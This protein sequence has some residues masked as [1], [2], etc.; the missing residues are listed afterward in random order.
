M[1][2]LYEAHRLVEQL[3]LDRDLVHLRDRLSPEVAEMVYYGFW[4]CAK[5]DALLAFIREAQQPVTRRGGAQ[6]STRATCSSRAARASH[7]LYDEAIA[8]MEGGG[9]YD[10]T[11]AE[12]FLRILGLP[13]RVQ[14]RVR[15]RG[16]ASAA[17]RSEPA[18][19]K[20]VLRSTPG[21]P[22]V[23]DL[24]AGSAAAAVRRLARPCR[25][26]RACV[27]GRRRRLADCWPC[28]AGDHLWRARGGQRARRPADRT[29]GRPAS[30]GF[31]FGPGESSGRGGRGHGGDGRLFGRGHGRAVSIGRPR[32]P[33]A[34][35]G[36]RGSAGGGA[37]RR[38]RLSSDWPPPPRLLTT[39][40]GGG[41]ARRAASAC[42]GLGGQPGLGGLLAWSLLVTL[43]L[44]A[45]VM[46]AR[47]RCRPS[48]G[49]AGRDSHGDGAGGHGGLFLSRAAV[50]R[51]YPLWPRLVCLS[52]GARRHRRR[53][54]QPGPGCRGRRWAG[55]AAGLAS[56]VAAEGSSKSGGRARLARGR[57]HAAAGRRRGSGRAPRHRL[58]G[59]A[60]GCGLARW[61]SSQ[62]RRP[63]GLPEAVNRRAAPCLAACRGDR[64]RRRLAA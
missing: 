12:G 5:M 6:L 57:G 50:R 31:P 19:M 3:T 22:A 46:A 25:G 43:G 4:Y 33:A 39:A 37:V 27:A 52:G 64:G 53:G 30:R 51:A 24:A 63:L 47:G 9:S 62:R 48:R 7:S 11:D 32:R 35:G 36:R 59:L 29:A 8:S 21:R 61:Q 40:P 56:R 13:L 55:P 14:G 54:P 41:V 49:A 26:R 60:A 45:A 28:A 10:Q 16:L 58:A 18:V 44:G 42:G 17:G 23:L 34:A 15:P 2:L 38:W 20:P 1:T